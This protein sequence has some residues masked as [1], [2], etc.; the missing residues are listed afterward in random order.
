M[1]HMKTSAHTNGSYFCMWV[2]YRRSEAAIYAAFSCLTFL[3]LNRCSVLRKESVAMCLRLSSV[4]REL[5]FSASCCIVV[6]CRG[7]FVVT[8]T[9]NGFGNQRLLEYKLICLKGWYS[10]F[11]YNH[12]RVCVRG[13]ILFGAYFG[14]HPISRIWCLPEFGVSQKR[15]PKTVLLG[16]IKSLTQHE[17]GMWCQFIGDAL[18]SLFFYRMHQNKH[19]FL[20]KQF[21]A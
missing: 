2:R 14:R 17:K 15:L 4:V 8:C 3:T 11:S 1:S 13:L 9:T 5:L 10:F 20:V 21:A 12:K 7:I 16:I 18:N 19:C 6:S